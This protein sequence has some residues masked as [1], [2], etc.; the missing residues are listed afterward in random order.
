MHVLKAYSKILS[1]CLQISSPELG[2]FIALGLRDKVFTETHMA[3]RSIL[4]LIVNL[5]WLPKYCAMTL[6]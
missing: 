3:G 2:N 1:A 5:L 6:G 4:I